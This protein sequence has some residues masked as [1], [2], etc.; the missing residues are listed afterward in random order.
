MNPLLHFNMKCKRKYLIAFA[1]NH[2]QHGSEFS[3]DKKSRCPTS[4]IFGAHGK[5]HF[6]RS[7]HLTVSLL[8][9]VHF[10]H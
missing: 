5:R 8:S 10:G 3:L 6:H 1:L 2:I 9:S 7:I 4:V